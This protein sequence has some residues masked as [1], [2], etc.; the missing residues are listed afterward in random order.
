MLRC[1]HDLTR[2]ILSAQVA[3]SDMVIIKEKNLY[4]F[5]DCFQME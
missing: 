4:L 3:S 5:F 1:M 2:A